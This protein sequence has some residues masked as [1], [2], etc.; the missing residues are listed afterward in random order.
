MSW[1]PKAQ[2]MTQQHMYEKFMTNQLEK[3][4]APRSKTYR[5]ILTENIRKL[6]TLKAGDN[7]KK[8]LT[9]ILPF[10]TLNIM[11]KTTEVIESKDITET[12]I[13]YGPSKDSSKPIKN[14]MSSQQSN[15]QQVKI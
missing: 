1:I 2:Q 7:A 12:Q 5:M 10:Q 13:C 4:G 6:S 8:R 9:G 15:Q 11:D 14:N 3:E